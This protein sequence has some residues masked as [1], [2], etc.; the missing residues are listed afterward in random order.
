MHEKSCL[1][2]VGLFDESLSTH[3][4]WDLIIRLSRKFKI[5]HIKETTCEFTQRKDGTNTSSH[6]RADF[7]RT[8]EII[9]N[10]Y[11]QY[12]EANPAILEAQ[13]E[14]FIAE[15]KELAQQVQNL[16]SQ[17][18]QKE[19]HLQ[20]TQA[21]KSQLA[22]QLETWQRSTQQ[23]QAKLEATQLEKNWVKSQ[24]NSWKQT[25]E[26]IQ[27]ELDRS[28]LK[29]KQAQSQLATLNPNSDKVTIN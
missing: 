15:A 3:E 19:S 18:I 14:A 4:D 20:Q 25:A 5:A 16:Q 29:L 8:R 11:R 7:T 9:F 22:A 24:L 12:A 10:Q 28:R 6:N 1:D 21:E 2:E 13:K 26:E 27:R 23:V 17:V